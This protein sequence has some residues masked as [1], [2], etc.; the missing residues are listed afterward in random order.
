MKITYSEVIKDEKGNY[1]QIVNV[2]NVVAD[3]I[4]EDDK[5]KYSF[6]IQDK[7]VRPEYF[8]MLDIVL[9]EEIDYGV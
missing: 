9:E 7:F 2:A 1:W 3:I 4:D 6:S 5:K 8:N